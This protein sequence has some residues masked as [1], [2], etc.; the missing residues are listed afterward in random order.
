MGLY[1]DDGLA[2]I[3]STI[4]P[5]LGKMKNIIALFKEGL[6]ITIDTNLI[7]TDFLDMTFN[8]ATGKFFPFRRKPNNVTLFINVKSNH[9]LQS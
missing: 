1:R 9:P 5:I 6:S 4:G 8:V 3:K 7:E 2:T